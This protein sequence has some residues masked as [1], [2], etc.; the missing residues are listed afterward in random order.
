[1]SNGTVKPF[2]FSSP[3]KL[4]EDFEKDFIKPLKES[5]GYKLNCSSY[6]QTV[7]EIGLEII[8]KID[9]KAIYDRSSFK[10]ELKKALKD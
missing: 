4:K 7:F 8:D 10:D 9:M 6:I 1:M 3:A 2:G 5:S